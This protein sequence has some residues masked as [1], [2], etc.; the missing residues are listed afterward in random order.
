M[1]H[2]TVVFL[3][4]LTRRLCHLLF[5]FHFAVVFCSRSGSVE[6]VVKPSE[7]LSL[8][9]DHKTIHRVQ[10]GKDYPCQM[11]KTQAFSCLFKHYA[12]HNGLKKDDLV[13]YF[14]DELKPEET[15]EN[16]HL[17]PNDEITVCRRVRAEDDDNDDGTLEEVPETNAMEQFRVLLLNEE[18]SDVTFVVGEEAQ[19]IFGHKAILSVR[20][21]YFRAM[22]QRRGAEMS[23]SNKYTIPQHSSP[24]F[25][26]M[27][28]FLYT[29]CIQN[30]AEVS[31]S[32]MIELIILADECLLHDNLLPRLESQLCS[33]DKITSKNVAEFLLL[34]IKHNASKLKDACLFY[35]K[36]H[37]DEL[38]TD[39]EFRKEV[40][41]NP[42]LSWAIFEADAVEGGVP[43]NSKK[44][45]RSEISASAD[46]PPAVDNAIP[47]I[48]Q[49]AN[50]NQISI[51][52]GGNQ[53]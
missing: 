29:D 26:R 43:G 41:L 6:F 46:A 31:T 15:P 24:T 30:L 23:T 53:D 4:N 50:S 5:S 32:E 45:K 9:G 20:S 49:L 51:G 16:V 7:D 37:R 36:E 33:E 38:K 13:F 44:R 12:K 17:M 21:E 18:Y 42:D 40:E 25:S 8:S 11:Q 27:L 22:F 34:S 52:F 14:T 2:V 48:P 10:K 19:P 39:M 28:E 3:S 47:A 1:D 35:I